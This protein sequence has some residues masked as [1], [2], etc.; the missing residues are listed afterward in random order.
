MKLEHFIHIENEA[1]SSD[2]CDEI[3]REYENSDDWVPGTVNDYNI[4]Q[5]RKCEAVYLSTDSVIEKNQEVRKNI[6]DRLF[7][8]VNDSLEKYMKKYNA[9]GYINVEGDTGYILLKYK[10]DDYVREHVDT[11]AGE[12]RTLSCSIILNDDYEGGEISFF[13]DKV[14]PFLKKGD[15][16][17][18]PSGFTYPH[19]VLPVTSGTRYAVITWIK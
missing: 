9:L 2:F 3:V 16:L 14:R 17:I 8:V 10:I 18:F 5:S 13:N 12:H 7:R 19:Q 11:Y 6:D 4:A 15:M 1:I